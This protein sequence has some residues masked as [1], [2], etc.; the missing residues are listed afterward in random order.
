MSRVLVLLPEQPLPGLCDASWWRVEAGAIVERGEDER[1]IELSGR[2]GADL[3]AL[4]PAGSVRL[5]VTEPVG[6]T[7]RQAAAIA[8]AGVREGSAVEGVGVHGVASVV[9]GGDQ[10]RAV[11]AVVAT[12]AMQQW[13]DWFGAVGRDPSAIVPVQLLLPE[14]EE[15]TDVRIGSEHL[16]GRGDLR[17][18]YEPGLAE[19]LIGEEHVRRLPTDELEA[20]LVRLAEAP[21]L[22]LRQGPFARRRRLRLERRQ[23]RELALLAAC[24]PLLALVTALVTIVRVNGAADRLD[25]KTVEVASA[26]LGRPVTAERALTELDL[27]AARSGGAGGSMSAPMAALFQQMQADQSVTAT[28]LGWRGDGTLSTTVAATRAEDINRLLI[29]LQRN[30]YQVTAVPRSGADGRQMADITMRS[31]A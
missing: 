4:A 24:I 14:A 16:V 29:A 7:D 23:I 1:W 2:D 30:G 3:V 6:A 20:E 21:P 19:A 26:A 9:G 17:F 15:W 13:L 28:T 12:A 10:R 5:Q 22:N 18:P 25:R 31:G 27:Q 8:A 11:A